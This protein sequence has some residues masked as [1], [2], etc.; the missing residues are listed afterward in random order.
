MQ[1]HLLLLSLLSPV[2]CLLTGCNIAGVI[3]SRGVGQ[4]TPAVY[5]PP[6]DQPML[7]IAESFRESSLS[8]IDTDQLTRYVTDEIGRYQ[9]APTIDP[10][11][12]ID[13]R[14]KDPKIYGKMSISEIGRKFG[15]QQVLY[16]NLVESGVDATVS[17][18]MRGRG[19][20]R[21]KIVNVATT[22]A[23]FPVD[24]SSGHSVSAKT[25][26]VEIRDGATVSMVRQDLQRQMA[27]QIVR[28]FR[29]WEQQEVNE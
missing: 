11:F 6:K 24:I 22:E 8:T 23:E 25:P 18:V 7:V 28:L 14:N 3:A 27:L 9:I 17:E 5:T 15:A 21:I 2:L 12:A 10:S 29:K 1:R 20:V 16:I 26:A 4:W 13:L 19:E